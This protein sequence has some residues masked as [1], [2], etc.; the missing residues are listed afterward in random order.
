MLEKE[1]MEIML[2]MAQESLNPDLYDRFLDCWNCMVDVRKGLKGVKKIERINNTSG[3][4]P[5]LITRLKSLRE[6]TPKDIMFECG[7]YHYSARS[8]I[9][10]V[11]QEMKN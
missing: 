11:I 3:F 7:D 6:H 4:I 1:V 8:V 5:D 10:E 2:L 9:D